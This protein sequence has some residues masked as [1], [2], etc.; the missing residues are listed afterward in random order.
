MDPSTIRKIMLSVY[1]LRCCPY[2]GARLVGTK[3]GRCEACGS[4]I[5][6]QLMRDL[7]R[8][9][10]ER[11]IYGGRVDTGIVKETI[12][13]VDLGE[14][15]QR[16]YEIIGHIERKLFARYRDD[17]RVAREKK[18]A[19]KLR[20]IY[21]EIRRLKDEIFKKLQELQYLQVTAVMSKRL[22][23]LD[24][25]YRALEKFRQELAQYI[26]P[27][28]LGM[29][30]IP[31]FPL[32]VAERL[33][34]AME[35]EK[36][37]RWYGLALTARLFPGSQP[38]RDLPS[39]VAAG[40]I[41]L[42]A[43]FLDAFDM[44]Y[45]GIDEVI[46]VPSREIGGLTIPC[47]IINES[48]VVWSGYEKYDIVLPKYGRF[49]GFQMLLFAWESAKMLDAKIL[50]SDGREVR[51]ELD[52]DTLY[53]LPLYLVKAYPMGHG[54]YEILAA[55][56]RGRV[57]ILRGA[58]NRLVAKSF[59]VG[60]VVDLTVASMD[61]GNRII[62]LTVDGRLVEIDPE[63]YD[64]GAI[65]RDIPNAESA[66]ISTGDID[67]DGYDE[68]FVSTVEGVIRVVSVN[69]EYRHAKIYHEES[70]CSVIND[71]DGDGE[72]E[73]LIIGIDGESLSI[74]INKMREFIGMKTFECVR[75]YAVR[76]NRRI[77]RARITMDKPFYSR[78]IFLSVD[79]DGDGSKEIFVGL[80][81][82]LVSLDFRYGGD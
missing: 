7:V 40:Y 25:A 77:G 28:V 80:D 45:D 46:F 42:G 59:V 15:S 13:A 23:D 58:E 76:F 18:D 2:C 8:V 52:G 69:G 33:Y 53:A 62:V 60:N 5:S 82:F 24:K 68:I 44:D 1:P 41:P 29:Y 61:R 81:R 51:V 19:E 38:K 30:V 64:V 31:E 74:H 21:N 67:G 79:A 55:G 70:I 43:I 4:E 72:N 66:T 16:V 54:E 9:Y 78:P 17:I 63:S 39:Y 56:T 49:G 48:G 71:V 65:V 73:L 34:E 20:E 26:D 12:H 10:I 50:D 3:N 57:F 37:T 22:E 35:Y 47:S 75:S 14:V 27:E 36:A 6:E 32:I 11:Q